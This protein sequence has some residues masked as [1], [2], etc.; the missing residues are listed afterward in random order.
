MH[1]PVIALQEL[2]LLLF[3]S[4]DELVEFLLGATPG[5]ARALVDALPSI[6]VSRR[7]YFLEAAEQLAAYGLDGPALFARLT[8]DRPGQS[9]AI[10]ATQ[11]H[12][13]SD[14]TPAQRGAAAVA[15]PVAPR[16]TGAPPPPELLTRFE[17]I[18]GERS[19]FLDVAYLGLGYERA[20]SVALLRLGFGRD[21]AYGTAFLVTPELLLTARHNLW[22]EQGRRA[23]VAW[24]EFDF[25]RSTAGALRRSSVVSADPAGFVGSITHDC[26]VLRLPRPQ[27]GRP[28]A[29]LARTGRLAREDRV[30]I[31]QHPRG[32]LKQVALHHNLVTHAGEE[33]V[34]YLTDTEA[35]SS[36]SPVFDAQWNVVAIHHAGGDLPVPGGDDRIYCNQGIAIGCALAALAREGVTI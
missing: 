30:A 33:R 34:Q 25:E 32:Q 1:R 27:T 18:L 23:D 28:L 14:A 7:R 19:T 3:R 17:K 16:D 11:A 31:I 22:D 4:N 13:L 12:Y 15:A 21:T 2:L 29:P 20:R 24:V 35:G 5:G 26:A 36:G 8:K 6:A 10:A 9:E